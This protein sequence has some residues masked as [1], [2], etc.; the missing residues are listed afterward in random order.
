MDFVFRP[1]AAV[2]I[3]IGVVIVAAVA[4]AFLK[5]GNTR[6]K[7]TGIVITVVVG[8]VLLIVLYRPVTLTVDANGVR[9][10]GLNPIELTWDEVDQAFLETDLTTSEFRPTVR[11]RGAAMGDYRT[12][13]FMLSNGTRARVIMER[14]DLAVVLITNDLTYLFAPDDIDG[15]IEAVDLY[16]PGAEQP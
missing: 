8:A 3:V 9:T 13:R 16:Y 14:S 6:R 12:G 10:T 1:P 7:I 15:L 2:L 11:T 4:S 5:K